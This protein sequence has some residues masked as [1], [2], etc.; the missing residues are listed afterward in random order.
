MVT[1]RSIL[2]FVLAASTLAGAQEVKFIDL[3]VNE[4]RTMLRYPPAESTCEAGKSCVGAGTAGGSVGD[5][6]PDIRDH[7]A[8]GVALDHISTRDI[9]LDPF[10]A[11]FR[12]VNT[13]L[14]PI[15]IPVFAHLSDLQP[16]RE[17]SSFSYLSL[18][19]VVD[20]RGTGPEQALGLGYVELYGASDHEGTITNLK[21][22]QWVRVKSKVK[23]H[24]WPTKPIP[25][26]LTG[27]FWLRRNVFTPH[28][29]GGFTQTENVYPNR[30]QFPGIEVRFT[31]ILTLRVLRQ[32][33]NSRE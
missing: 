6:A 1:S 17:T 14:L 3:S 31:P 8:L 18:A 24:T 28:E 9:T 10:E 7:H 15:D 25:A 13:G 16:P 2:S 4:Q 12:I 20:L 23:M 32:A 19:L 30:T 5:G 26:M 21:P 11:E 33:S 29:G 22:G 27:N